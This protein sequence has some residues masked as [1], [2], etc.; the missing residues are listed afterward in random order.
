[1]NEVIAQY[2]KGGISSPRN[3]WIKF[4]DSVKKKHLLN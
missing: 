3:K 4:D 2:R 1:M